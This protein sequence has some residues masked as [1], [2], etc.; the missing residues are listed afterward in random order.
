MSGR[1]IVSTVLERAAQLVE[2]GWCQHAPA[3]SWDGQ[4]RDPQVHQDEPLVAWSV[5]GALE[6]AASELLA[7]DP[8]AVL[9]VIEAALQALAPGVIEHAA[10][11]PRGT[12]EAFDRLLALVCDWNDAPG[13]TGSEVVAV[14]REAAE[15]APT[16]GSDATVP[17]SAG[18]V[19]A[20][21][22]RPRGHAETRRSRA[23]RRPAPPPGGA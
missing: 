20:P 16:P 17:G 18:S 8:H 10:V 13:R 14:L 12:P 2:E 9:D 15:C 11:P 21:A 3:R 6:Q 5:V 4:D 22:R 19:A 1:A 23:A 7:P